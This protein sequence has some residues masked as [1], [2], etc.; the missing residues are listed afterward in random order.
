MDKIKYEK[1]L[2]FIPKDL[3]PETKNKAIEDISHWSKHIRSIL[4]PKMQKKIPVR[5]FTKDRDTTTI[6]LNEQKFITENLKAKE[7]INRIF[8]N[9][10][11]RISKEV[12]DNSK[13][14]PTNKAVL[15]RL[16]PEKRYEKEAFC[17]LVTFL[18]AYRVPEY[19]LIR[20][21][22]KVGK[23]EMKLTKVFRKWLEKIDSHK[24]WQ[25]R[26]SQFISLAWSK[27]SDKIMY[28]WSS[29]PYDMIRQSYASFTSCHWERLNGARETQ[30]Y[31]TLGTLG[32]SNLPWLEHSLDYTS[33]VVLI[34]GTNQMVNR[35]V[36][37]HINTKTKVF[38]FGRWYPRPWVDTK[39]QLVVTEIRKKLKAKGF[40]E[41]SF[42]S[43]L[44][45]TGINTDKTA[46]WLFEEV[47]KRSTSYFYPDLRNEMTGVTK[48]YDPR[49]KIGLTNEE[50]QTWI[51]W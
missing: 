38:S 36:M 16:S 18:C 3:K 48:G 9:G 39:G 43:N 37:L 7:E 26:I 1:Y 46:G 4:G 27:K 44:A 14:E 23:Q 25:E 28:T 41:I 33:T 17:L 49:Y 12:Q 30:Y 22:L 2:D 10:S 13:K 34:E 15:E 8:F 40:E 19:G 51:K 45:N 20:N 47:K 6:I 42:K 31:S 21:K 5:I 24:E 11:T 35:R 32:P 29:D 50:R